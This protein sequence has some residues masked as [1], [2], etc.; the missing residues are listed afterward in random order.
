MPNI[1]RSAAYFAQ[2][3]TRVFPICAEH[4]SH[5]FNPIETLPESSIFFI[6]I[7]S[8]VSCK[9]V[10]YFAQYLTQLYLAGTQ[11]IYSTIHIFCTTFNPIISCGRAAYFANFNRIF[12]CRRAVY[13]KNP[14]TLFIPVG[15]QHI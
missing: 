1:C 11:H 12:S 2:S 15:G 9:R 6:I 4:V 7:N 8:I 10:S 3:F 14:I 5:I 13:L